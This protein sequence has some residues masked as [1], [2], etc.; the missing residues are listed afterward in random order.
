MRLR[1]PQHDF[2]EHQ[3][4]GPLNL[5]TWTACLTCGRRYHGKMSVNLR[6]ASHNAFLRDDVEVMVATV[7]YG[8]CDCI[9]LL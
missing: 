3:R 5:S 4:C 7:A 6:R 2:C 8:E 1:V 9:T